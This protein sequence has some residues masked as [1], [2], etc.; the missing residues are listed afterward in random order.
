M[1]D[2][3][4]RLDDLDHFLSTQ[5]RVEDR[6]ATEILLS[7]LVDCPRTA[8]LWTVFETAYY[9]RDCTRAWFS[10]G[11]SWRPRS[12]GAIRADRPRN[13]HRDL[14]DWLEDSSPRLFIE[15]DFEQPRSIGHLAELPFLLGKCLRIRARLTASVATQPVDERV[16][17]QR[18]DELGELTRHVLEDRISARPSDPPRWSEP[19]GF[20]YYTELAQH[21]GGWQRSWAELANLLRVLAVRRAYI[22][23]RGEVGEEDWP[24]LQRVLRDTVPVWITRAIERLRAGEDQRTGHLVLARAMRIDSDPHKADIV[25]K[26][27]LVRL[28]RAGL[29]HYDSQTATWKLVAEHAS[30]VGEVID[31]RAFEARTTAAQ[32]R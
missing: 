15:P 30:G 27:E 19:P 6:I 14:T 31:G 29:I 26:R 7:A 9:S 8:G 32:A 18:A 2:W 17:Q 25:A 10:F 24:V 11:G 21:L 13:L 16:D 4:A 5:Y 20:R 12:M 1:L 22:F 23:G 3:S 28:H